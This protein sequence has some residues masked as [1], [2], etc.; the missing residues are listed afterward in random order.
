M[1]LAYH[2][3]VRI[4]CACAAIAFGLLLFFA[5]PRGLGMSPDSVAYLRAAKDFLSG[6]WLNSFTSQWP[7]LYPTLIILISKPLGLTATEGARLFQALLYSANFL[8]LYQL[9]RTYSSHKALSSILFAGLLGLQGVITYIYFYAWTEPLFILIILLDLIILRRLLS[10]I[11][12]SGTAALL[13]ATLICLAICAVSTR[14]IGLTVAILNGL[15][16]ALYYQGQRLQRLTIATTHVL[17][18]LLFI[19]PW[20][21]YRSVFQDGNTDRSF[22][23]HGLSLDTVYSGLGTL[24]RWVI[25]N[26]L[27]AGHYGGTYLHA[28]LGV[29]LLLFV[30]V[31]SI[32]CLLFYNGQKTERKFISLVSHTAPITLFIAIYFCAILFFIV[33]VDKKIP[34]DN[35]ILAPIFLP[36]FV[37]LISLSASVSNRIVGFILSAYLLVVLIFFYPEFRSRLLVSYFDG[38]E[39]TSKS[40]NNKKIIALIKTCDPTVRVGADLP[41]NYDLYFDSK[42]YW[43]PRE[44][45]FGSGLINA[46]FKKQ[47]SLLESNLDVIVIEDQSSSLVT[48]VNALRQFQKVYGHDG[49]VWINKNSGFPTCRF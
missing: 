20:L 22:A 38:I 46:N 8:A 29:T 12:N 16:V 43:L 13:N 6:N 10:P 25:P 35:R 30:F 37:F 39:L 40:I 41:W 36:V 5:T 27:P 21:R 18:P 48:E 44:L 47:M 11:K 45:L 34:L 32:L 4:V 31:C 1:R 19:I 42:V 26:H 15:I 49:H 23:Y 3:F 2:W 14:Y 28:T 9:I 24:G 7:P 33:F 17:L